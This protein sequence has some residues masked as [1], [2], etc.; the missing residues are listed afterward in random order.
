MNLYAYVHNNALIHF[1]EYGLFVISSPSCNFGQTQSYSEQFEKIKPI[2]TN[3]RFLG[4]MQAFGGLSEMSA[5]AGISFG[6]GFLAAPIGFGVMAHGADHFTT[7]MRQVFSG[8]YAET[9]TS[10]ILQ[11]SGLPKEWAEI[12]DNSSSVFGFAKGA[13]LNLTKQTFT[14]TPR[15]FT[16]E[17]RSEFS[18]STTGKSSTLAPPVRKDILNEHLK[19]WEKYGREGIRKLQNGSTRYYG[20]LESPRIEGEMIGRRLV[21]EWD[22]KTGMKRTWHETLDGSGAVE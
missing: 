12:A 2:L 1:D 21:R 9:A 15:M 10:Q 3:P 22:P 8:S 19:Q 11:K 20:A 16:N 4:A 7:G 13:A 5:G 14:S 18:G 6:T 17:L